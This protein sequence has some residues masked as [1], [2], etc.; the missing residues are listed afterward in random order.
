MLLKFEEEARGFQARYISNTRVYPIELPSQPNADLLHCVL[1]GKTPVMT[2]PI[3]SRSAT[4]V[5]ERQDTQLAGGKAMLIVGYFRQLLTTS[6]FKRQS[7]STGYTIQQTC[8]PH[9]RSSTTLKIRQLTLR[10]TLYLVNMKEEHRLKLLR[11]SI[12]RQ[13]RRRL[14]RRQRVDTTSYTS[15]S[16]SSQERVMSSTQWES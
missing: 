8:S 5:D 15:T 11:Q 14:H 7:L 6:G 9:I 3:I 1:E 13:P 12:P 4:V 16:L 10:Q 2:A